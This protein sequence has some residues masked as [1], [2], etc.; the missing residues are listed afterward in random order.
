MTPSPRAVEHQPV[1]AAVVTGAG[2]ALPATLDQDAV[3]DG[4]FARALRGRPR[5]PA[6]LRR[7]R[8]APPARGRQPDGR[9]P[10]QLGHRRPD[11]SATSRRRCRWASRRW[12]ARWTPP[13]WRPGTSGCSPSSPA[14]ATRPRGWT[15]GWPATWAC[16]R[17]AAAARR[18]HGLL[19]RHPGAGRG[20]R[21]RHR[22]LPPGRAAV[23]RADQPARAAGAGRPRAGGGA[24]A[25]LR[26]GGRRGRRAR[27]LPA[28]G[29][30]P[31]SSP[32]PTAP[33]PTT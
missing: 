6:D 16:R 21:L 23:L 4:F 5:G 29:G 7:G 3:W 10:Q 20:Q 28:A 8:G 30:W 17:A 19:R 1:S 2:S 13:G 27:R 12:P 33:P 26:R 11:G 15:S 24:R 9:G 31:A 32:A 18:A 14:R 25:V 22:A